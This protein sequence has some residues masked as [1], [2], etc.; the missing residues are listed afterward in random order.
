MILTLP[1]PAL[2]VVAALFVAAPGVV[3][4]GSI[5]AAQ[6]PEAPPKVASQPLTTEQLAVYRTV[7]VSWYEGE[8]AKVNL[9][10]LT[11]PI[12]A[13]D[14]SLD[15]RCRKGLS[16][17]AVPAGQVHRI[18]SED[19]AQ[20]GPFEFHLV[21]PKAGEKEVSDNDPGKAIQK[22]KSVN[23]AVENGFAHGLLTLGEIQFDKSHTHAL[24]SFSFVCGS[25]CGNGATMLL[26]KKDGVWTERAQCG[27]WVS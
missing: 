12:A 22:G 14:D 25:L 27:G 4:L 3:C 17:E 26:E 9:G 20:L 2:R 18:R 11:D 19:L 5:L 24:V 7:L 21:D 10:V 6:P 8:K 1:R 13:P 23:D 15:K 16:L